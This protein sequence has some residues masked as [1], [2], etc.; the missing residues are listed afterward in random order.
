MDEEE[1]NVS[2]D[3]YHYHDP[4]VGEVGPPFS[5]PSFLSSVG[6]RGITATMKDGSL[7]PHSHLIILLSIVLL[8]ALISGAV[9]AL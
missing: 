1:L 7:E 6:K 4:E 2:S 9:L 3:P 5:I 8:I